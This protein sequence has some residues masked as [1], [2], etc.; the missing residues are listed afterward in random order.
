M[1]TINGIR[2]KNRAS[3]IRSARAADSGVTVRHCNICRRAFT[4]AF[5]YQLFCG[6]CRIKE[7]SFMF[8]EWLPR[9]PERYLPI[10]GGSL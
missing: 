4:P 6:K 1:I 10:Q 8:H 5:R 7:D 9:L 2:F 3:E